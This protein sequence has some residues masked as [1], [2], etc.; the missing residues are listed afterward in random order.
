MNY[1]DFKL[2]RIMYKLLFVKE[3]DTDF[4][5]KLHHKM[6]DKYPAEYHKEYH[7]FD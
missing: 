7:I 2:P 5:N 3:L 6:V 1:L 4:L